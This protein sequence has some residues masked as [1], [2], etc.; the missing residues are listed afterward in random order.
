MRDEW[1]RKS[2][3]RESNMDG[4]EMK[5]GNRKREEKRRVE[6]LASFFFLLNL[7]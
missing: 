2:K 3:K 1:E 7:Y 6:E 4:M 5:E